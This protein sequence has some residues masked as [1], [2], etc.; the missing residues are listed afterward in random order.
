MKIYTEV[1]WKVNYSNHHTI[2]VGTTV[3][4]WCSELIIQHKS[5]LLLLG[6]MQVVAHGRNACI[7]NF[8]PLDFGDK[9]AILSLRNFCFPLYCSS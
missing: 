2:L 8:V 3:T 9:K 5:K 1:F 4:A 6:E 7:V